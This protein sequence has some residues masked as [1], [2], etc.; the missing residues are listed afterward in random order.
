MSGAIDI[1]IDTN[2][3]IASVEGR[4]DKKAPV[5][6]R[7]AFEFGTLQMGFLWGVLH[8]FVPTGRIFAGAHIW[9]NAYKTLVL[10]YGWNAEEAC[11][12]INTCK[13]LVAASGGDYGVT[14]TAVTA[15]EVTEAAIKWDI[16]WEDRFVLQLAIQSGARGIITEDV[17]FSRVRH[18]GVAGIRVRQ[19]AQ[20]VATDEVRPTLD[21]SVFTS[22]LERLNAQELNAQIKAN[23]DDLP[24]KSRRALEACQPVL[25]AA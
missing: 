21:M 16:D 14:P 3:I 15:R 20:L 24:E 22:E 7:S 12:W 25:V 4:S 10:K 5:L 19:Y 2:V 6:N 18:L 11:R 1:V 8:G 13:A 17:A 9:A 23:T